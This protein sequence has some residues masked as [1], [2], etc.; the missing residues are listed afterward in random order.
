[1]R[2][3]TVLPATHT[4]IHKWNEP[5]LPLLPSRRASQVLIFRPAEGRRLS[6][7]INMLAAASFNCAVSVNFHTHV[8]RQIM[9]QL[10][11]AVDISRLDYCNDIAGLPKC[12]LSQ[13]QPIQN[14]AVRFVLGLQPRN[15]IYQSSTV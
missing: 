13:L 1:M 3:H 7:P 12:L 4:F 6:W 2:D 14:A 15:R 10:A 11:H 8:I 5:Y 9:K